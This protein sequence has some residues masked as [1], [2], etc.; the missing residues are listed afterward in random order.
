[1]PRI[2]RD[3]MWWRKQRLW[4]QQVFEWCVATRRGQ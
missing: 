4:I 2:V 1:M 3:V